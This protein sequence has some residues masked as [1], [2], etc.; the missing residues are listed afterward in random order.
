MWIAPALLTLAVLSGRG[1]SRLWAVITLAG[2]AV[3]AAGPQWW[4]PSGAGRELRWAAWEQAAG[5][6]Y[7]LFAV[8]VL[9]LSAFAGTAITRGRSPYQWSAR[10]PEAPDGAVL[11]GTTGRIP[12]R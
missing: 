9:A 12:G 2:V 6:S 5:S 10:D 11:P 3:F 8:V 7:V 4:F 1:R